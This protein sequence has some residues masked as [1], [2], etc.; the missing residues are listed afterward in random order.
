MS[1]FL[2]SEADTAL[3]ASNI[4]KELINCLIDGKLFSTIQNQGIEDEVIHSDEF[5]AI[6]TTCAVFHNTLNTSS[7]IPNEHFL[8]AISFL[9]LKLGECT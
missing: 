3:K 5:E 9:F 8:A 4:F 6:K 1:G 7:R 2:S